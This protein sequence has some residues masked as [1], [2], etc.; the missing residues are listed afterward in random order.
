MRTTEVDAERQRQRHALFETTRL[1]PWMPSVG[2]M[3]GVLLSGDVVSLSA[4]EAFA[5]QLPADAMN[6]VISL[7]HLDAIAD[8]CGTATKHGRL[9][10]FGRLPWDALEKAARRAGP[11][12]NQGVLGQPFGEPWLMR[13]VDDSNHVRLILVIPRDA[14]A[15]TI[16]GIGLRPVYT[17][18]TRAL[19]VD[20]V[21]GLMPNAE[22]PEVLL[23]SCLPC[24]TRWLTLERAGQAADLHS[25]Q[26]SA[27]FAIL[28][29]LMAALLILSTRG[30]ERRTVAP[31]EK[32]VRARMRAGKPPIPSHQ[33]VDSEPYVTA[34]LKRATAS[35]EPQGGTHA[36]PRPH[37]RMAH[38]RT[39]ANG[40]QTWVADALVN[41]SA[42][43]KQAF[44]SGRSHYDASRLAQ[45][46]LSG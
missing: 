35:G 41:F 21:V 10:D 7:D 44:R 43:A 4:Q 34:L 14:V 13:Y 36:S 38:P 31:S 19:L 46:A 8:L 39:L 23:P 37:L 20:D 3:R 45:A 12:F 28:D 22:Q 40:Q 1:E 2:E 16:T 42:E 30:I 26:L 32:L 15:R 17:A 9:I 29:P 24:F 5:L 33:V 18:S 25:L 27:T 11:L 6:S